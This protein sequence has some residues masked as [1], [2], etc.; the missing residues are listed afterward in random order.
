MKRLVLILVAICCYSLS[1]WADKQVAG[2]VVDAETGEPIIGA[3]VQPNGGGSGTATDVDGKF[4]LSVPDNVKDITVS[5]VGMKQQVVAATSN[6]VVRLSGS[7]RELDEVVV[8]ALGMKRD[9]KALGYAVQDLKAD[10][11][12][13]KGS[14][15][16]ANAITGKISGVDIRPSSGMPGASTNIVIRGARSFEGSNQPLYVID[17]MPIS[18]ES[19]FRNAANT[20]VSGT[21]YSQRSLDINPEDIESIN[22]LK[23]QAASAL[24]GIRASNGV[25]VIT[26]K[27]GSQQKGKPAVSLTTSFSAE[28]ASRMFH[29]QDEYAQGINGLYGPQSSMTWGPKI[30]ELPNDPTYG[31]NVANANNGNDATK[32]QGK[33]YN[34][35][36]ANAG[37]GD[38]SGWVVP[39]IHDN[40][41]D[42]LGTGFTENT[43]VNL[44]QN[45]G[46]A[47]YSFS[48]SNAHQDGIVP[49]SG[50]DRWGARGL[51]DWNINE[52]WKTGFS[53]NYTST[54][55][56]SIPGGNSG[57]MNVIY[58]APA[59]YDLKGVPNHLPGQPTQQTLFR[60]ATFNNPYWW[61]ENNEYLQHTNRAFGNAYLEFRP[62]VSWGQFWIREQAGLDIYTND[63]D[64]IEEMGSARNAGGSIL[65]QGVTN[66][67][68]NNLITANYSNRFGEDWALD[69]MIGNE[70]NH[71]QQRNWYYTGTGFNFYGM[72]TIGNAKTYTSM[73]ATYAERSIG[74]FASVN[75]SWRD[76]IYLSATGRNDWLSSMPRGHRSFFY[77]SVSASWL[78][79]QLDA[80]RNNP[81]LSF[82]KVRLSYASVG[83]AGGYQNNFFYTPQYSSGMYSGTVLSYPFQGVS[84]YVPYWRSYD[85][86]LKPQNTKNIET[87]IDLSFFHDRLRL[88]Y[89]YSYQDV[90]DQIMNV[91]QAG[92][93]GYQ[94]MVTNGGQIITNSHEVNLA[95]TLF[96][97][98]DW[99]A[100]LGVS[101]TKINSEVKKL[102]AGVESIM[103]TGYA[104]PQIRAEV[105]SPF[106]II[107][108]IG[109][110]RDPEG[111]II[112]DPETHLPLATAG[113]INIGNAA[114]DF[115]MGFNLDLRYKRVSL[116]TTWTWQQG[117]KMFFGSRG[118]MNMFGA[119]QET[120]DARN[121]G[122]VE[123][124]GVVN[125][126]TAENPVYTPWSGT[127]P[128]Q[129][130]YVA[131]GDISEASVFDTSFLKMRDLTINYNLP[132]I[133]NLDVTV[134]GFA[135]NV[136]VWAKMPEF[137]PESSLGN[138]N[139]GGYFENY[140]APQTMSFGGG[141]KLAF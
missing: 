70:I 76:M 141:L 60:S 39:T 73:E 35:I 72:P 90:T 69:A 116:S 84:T 41:S 18:S 103:L 42:F 53:V 34:P 47:S 65:N 92:S 13:T 130:Y 33:Y 58:S 81:V 7:S 128:A 112:L 133:G 132:K 110:Q 89:T 97:N 106:P 1:A 56:N 12:N 101:F 117:G 96:K 68:F 32:Y 91:P 14:T 138:N 6:V 28:R 82:G 27:R 75:L 67:T 134:Y 80:L 3:T 124:S 23:G 40:V 51:V 61:A 19:D 36:Y 104:T 66:N 46:Q 16:L 140:A 107:Y 9:R 43:T 30:S 25:I 102:A 44:S 79:T 50:M 99:S 4:S 38:G 74:A 139:G 86:N 114:P 85:E 54:K 8:T 49:S 29:H 137:D 88:D 48:L 31:G 26:T 93:S 24:Y 17:G 111:N 119:T 22:V 57:I 2:Q 20:A 94:Q 122:G 136:L 83:Q 125:T 5:Y 59:E 98:K 123:V 55:V 11:L 15:D 126:G 64:E 45:V 10:D 63:N 105:G 87:G 21:T 108:G 120:A 95:A 77:P 52:A 113:D 118:V 131:M 115:N 37:Y 135:R 78:F 62:K 109:Y 71:Q 100:D 129:D 121:N 127:V